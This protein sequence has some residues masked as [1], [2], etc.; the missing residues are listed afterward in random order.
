MIRRLLNIGFLFFF[1]NFYIIFFVLKGPPILNISL[2][3]LSA[4][5]FIFFNVVPI[6]NK[7]PFTRGEVL[8]GGREL[9]ICA[10]FLV[11]ADIFFAIF[12]LPKIGLNPV[13]IVFSVLGTLIIL[14]IVSLNGVIRIIGASTQLSLVMKLALF[15]AWWI[16]LLNLFIVWHCCRVAKHE[17]LFMVYKE[18]LNESRKDSDVCRTKYPL[19]MVHGIFWRDWQIFNYWGRISKELLRNGAVVYYG[20]QQSAAPMEI[21]ASELKAQILRI[22]ETEHCEKVNIIAHSKGGLDAR[23]AISCLGAAPYVA[24]LTA[25]GAPHLGCRLVDLAKEKIPDPLL[26][27]FAKGY[28]AMYRKLG[29]KDPDFISGINDLTTAQCALFNREV[30]DKEGVFY[31]SVASKM[32]SFFSA[33]F[34]LN[35]GYAILRRT[36]GEND[37]FVSVE[38]SKWGRYLGCFETKGRRGVSHGDMIDLTRKNIKGFDA[39]ERYVDIVKGLKAQG[40]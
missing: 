8:M 5:C 18:E 4:V 12:F 29:D 36:D 7:R 28:N 34:P 38:S 19:L 30:I 24:S 1:S 2:F 11:I 16:P 15:F 33:D 6:W 14:L 21:C 39:S 35:V 31:A 13:A 40:L 3:A 27:W 22:L 25:I 23:Y 20:N 26:R 37:G 9:L 32:N 10:F 17:Y